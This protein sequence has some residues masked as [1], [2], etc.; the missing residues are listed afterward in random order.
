MEY[1]HFKQE[2]LTY[3][4][5][6]IQKNYYLTSVDLKDAYFSD[7]VRTDYKKFL[8]FFWKMKFYRFVVFPFG[9][10]SC[11]RILT[12]ILK[13]V[14]AFFRE[15]G[16]ICCYYI[17]DSLIM[18]QTFSTCQEQ[19]NIVMSELNNLGFTIN[20]QKSIIIPSQRIVYFGVIIDS[21]EF[22]V[23]LKD[24]KIEKILRQGQLILSNPRV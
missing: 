19:T 9:L 3:G 14:Y 13:P 12:K 24:E 22:K 11:P 8:T 23:Y 1:Y 18:N 15:N 21:V 5:E 10:T 7:S 17:D 6:L 2:N 4:L 16:I 20:D